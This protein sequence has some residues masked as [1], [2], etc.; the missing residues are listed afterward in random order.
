MIYEFNDIINISDYITKTIIFTGSNNTIGYVENNEIT[1][2]NE[3]YIYEY[4]K[5]SWSIGKIENMIMFPC[6]V[7]AVPT[8]DIDNINIINYKLW[9]LIKY[10]PSKEEI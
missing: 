10:I 6:G 1:I 7:G 8:L 3:E 2:Q 9:D 5:G 4:R